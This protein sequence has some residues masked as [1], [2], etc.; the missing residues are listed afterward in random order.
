M[1]IIN[2]PLELQNM[3]FFIHYAKAKMKYLIIILYFCVSKC[4]LGGVD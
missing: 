3:P 4:N 1:L 2:L